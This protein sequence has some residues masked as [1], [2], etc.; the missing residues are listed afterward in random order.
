MDVHHI[1]EVNKSGGHEPDNLLPLCPYCH[2]KYHRKLIDARSIADWKARVSRIYLSGTE[3]PEKQVDTK[4][5]HGY[6]VAFAS[7]ARR[8]FP[9]WYFYDYDGKAKFFPAGYATYISKQTLISSRAVIDRLDQVRANIPG[10]RAEL[11][12]GFSSLNFTV[13]EIHTWADIVFLKGSAIESREHRREAIS[14]SG[15]LDN[16]LPDESRLG[17]IARIPFVGQ[18]VA[19]LY[20]A[21]YV[22]NHYPLWH[23]AL[24]CSVISSF[25][26]SKPATLDRY[27]LAPICEPVSLLGG[28]VFLRDGTLVGVLTAPRPGDNISCEATTPPLIVGGFLG[29][30]KLWETT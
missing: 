8:T 24:G 27:V 25:L 23:F 15:S 4:L 17:S 6:S 18:D 14:E 21:H 3:R 11:V 29:I 20:G 13:E 26:S 12:I 1:V 16:D 9:V 28:P 5:D 22:D 19:F 30:R 10:G 2:D 7:Y